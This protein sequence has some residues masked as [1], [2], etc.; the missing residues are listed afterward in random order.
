MSRFKIHFLPNMLKKTK[1]N[2]LVIFSP[3]LSLSLTS[4]FSNYW[5]LLELVS[6]FFLSEWF[7][8]ISFHKNIPSN[9]VAF[10]DSIIVLKWISSILYL[11]IRDRY[12]LLFYT[13]LINTQSTILDPI[14]KFLRLGI[15]TFARHPSY[16]KVFVERSFIFIEFIWCFF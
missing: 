14:L 4:L 1:P 15:A 9:K 5:R 10:L 8:C 13:Y 7:S 3:L 6:I 2:I 11:C 12:A 16:I